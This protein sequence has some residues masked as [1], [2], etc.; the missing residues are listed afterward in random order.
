MTKHQKQCHMT[1]TR[2]TIAHETQLYS[3]RY[4]YSA[5]ISLSSCAPVSS[6]RAVLHRSGTRI[7]KRLG[8]QAIYQLPGKFDGTIHISLDRTI[9]HTNFHSPNTK[10]RREIS[11][12]PQWRVPSFSCSPNDGDGRAADGDQPVLFVK[13]KRLAPLV[14]ARMFRLTKLLP[15][16][17]TGCWL[18]TVVPVQLTPTRPSMLERLIPSSWRM[19]PYADSAS[20][21]VGHS[22]R[23][24]RTR[25]GQGYLTD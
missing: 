25:E 7:H 14:F 13:R 4:R 20:C 23:K 5:F 21:N 11:R 9:L 1:L 19:P 10:T 3:D 17:Q 18:H 22:Q 16:Q 15:V 12:G 6:H 8:D 24:A 2:A